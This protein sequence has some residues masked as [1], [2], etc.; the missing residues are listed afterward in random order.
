[1]PALKQVRQPLTEVHEHLQQAELRLRDIREGSQDPANSRQALELLWE[2]VHALYV[3][4]ELSGIERRRLED[5][6][7]QLEN[8]AP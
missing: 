7:R 6:I 8:D 4:V 5:R 3:E 2:A 1:M